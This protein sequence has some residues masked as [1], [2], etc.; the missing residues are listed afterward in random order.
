MNI[1]AISAFGDNPRYII[2]AY[3]QVYLAK[4]YFPDF[5]VWLFVDKPERYRLPAKVIAMPPETN[6]SFWRFLAGINHGCIIFRDADSRISH[7][8]LV[9]TTEWMQSGK[10][11]HIM[12]DHERHMNNESIP[13][14]AGMFGIR[15][16][17]PSASIGPLMDGMNKPFLYNKDQ[18]FLRNYVYP[19]M[20][21]DALVH[22]LD[23][24]W[25]G[26]SRKTLIN[27]YNWVGQGWD[28]DDRPWYANSNEG[29][30][31]FDRFS[32]P[33]SARFNQYP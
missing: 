9:A 28:E 27:P 11:L 30:N 13:I 19:I 29:F 25:F 33:E 8:E 17:W 6:G 1:F 23:S 26:E 5:E 12:R 21:D 32:L 20:Q 14:L 24:G 2:G 16:P 15:G 22:D 7:R 10:R 18:D 4:H 31:S 3:K